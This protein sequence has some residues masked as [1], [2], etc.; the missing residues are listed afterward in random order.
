MVQLAPM[1][2]GRIDV[3]YRRVE[4]VP[5]APM[6]VFVD[7]NNGPGGWLRLFIGK[8]FSLLLCRS[9]PGL[10]DHKLQMRQ[11]AG[12]LQEGKKQGMSS[13]HAVQSSRVGRRP[14]RP[15]KYARLTATRH[16]RT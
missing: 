15:C 12:Q 16:G 5:P 13:L 11:A 10:V 8:P 6:V 14:W 7:N 2:N 1:A 3:Q 4:C 9:P